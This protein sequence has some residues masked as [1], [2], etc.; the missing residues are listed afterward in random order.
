MYAARVRRLTGGSCACVVAAAVLVVLL[1]TSAA[2]ASL[3]DDVQRAATTYHEA[4]Q[5][6]DDVRAALEARLAAGAD[7]PHLVAA[8]RAAFLW[9]DFRAAT[10]GEKIASYERGR[11][12]AERA[13]QLA[14]RDPGAHFWWAVNTGRWSEAKGAWRARTLL[15]SLRQEVELVLELDPTYVDGYAFLGTMYRRLPWILGGD[16]VRAEAM[17][18]KG[19]ELDP[20]YTGL[21]VGLAKVLM[22]TGRSG[23]ARVELQ[24]VL[25][26]KSPRNRAQWTLEN[27]PEAAKLLETL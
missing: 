16:N 20:A 22:A 21:R 5:R 6:I 23:E 13:R 8:S 25:D 4:P 14:P 1:P 9:A 11:D 3:L 27:A 10:P 18:R 7:V 26:E 15:R 24:R 17:Y 2:P 19:L 12:L